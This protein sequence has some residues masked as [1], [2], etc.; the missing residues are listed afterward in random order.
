[1]L[2]TPLGSRQKLGHRH[3]T[4]P[5]SFFGGGDFGLCKGTPLTLGPGTC[6]HPVSKFFLP[7]DF[8]IQHGCHGDFLIDSCPTRQPC[9]DARATRGTWE[10]V[11]MSCL[12]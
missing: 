2:D 3:V 11:V 4:S 10:R 1:M 8:V 5:V 9:F 6:S 12:L 7:T